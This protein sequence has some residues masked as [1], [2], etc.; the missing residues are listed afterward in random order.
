MK[1]TVY[2]F[3][4]ASLAAIAIVPA[5]NLWR[6]RS[7]PLP[8][9]AVWWHRSVL[10][11]LDFAMPAVGHAL[12]KRG[13]SL[14][15]GQAII[16]RDGWLFLG[17]DY[18]QTISMQRR[19]PTEQDAGAAR[20]IARATNDW[21]AWFKAHGVRGFVV[22]VGADK[23]SVYPE[24]LPEWARPVGRNAT[25]VLMETVNPAIYVDT[26]EAL[27]EARGSYSVPLY[28]RTDTH[29]N[30]LGA[31]IAFRRFATAV[32]TR[33]P[34]LRWPA[35]ED[36]AA[37]EVVAREGGDLTD[38]LRLSDEVSDRHVTMQLAPPLRT[39]IEQ[40]REKDGKRVYWGPNTNFGAPYRPLLV[41]S[42]KS[43][44]P[45][46]VLWLRD[47]FGNAMAPYMAATFAET[48]QM[49]FGRTTPETVA[50]MVRRFKPKYVFITVVERDARQ[51]WFQQGPPQD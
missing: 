29:W 27:R 13:I 44:N 40:F 33:Y 2:A 39:W 48:L 11:N 46:R 26:R 15:P 9:G 42:R 17:D 34:G 25:D 12:Y 5:I 45:H 4:A 18:Q 37:S 3:I 31:W 1:K 28:Y 24:N 41:R 43:L 49:H 21:N 16:G 51:G 50:K 7:V 36:V 47:S 35:E 10:Y 6:T 23:G 38:F 32:D 20:R 8:E 22:M 14:D 30:D 19:A